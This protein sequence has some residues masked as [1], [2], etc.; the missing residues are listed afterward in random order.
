MPD[1]N[2]EHGL[3]GSRNVDAVYST[4]LALGGKCCVFACSVALTKVRAVCEAYPEALMMANARGQ[5][6]LHVA[7]ESNCT[8]EAFVPTWCG[9]QSISG[10]I[11]V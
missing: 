3:G 7:L 11:G 1:S 10:S 9:G 5:L 8:I 6:P 2:C 4:M